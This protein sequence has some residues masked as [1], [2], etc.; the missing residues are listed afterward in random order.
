[1]LEEENVEQMGG[2]NYGQNGRSLLPMALALAL[3]LLLLP[4]S[5]HLVIFF[6]TFHSQHP[7]PLRKYPI[8]NRDEMRLEACLYFNSPFPNQTSVR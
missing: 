2:S 6:Q 3:L 7:I 8:W 4:T 5:N 1:M